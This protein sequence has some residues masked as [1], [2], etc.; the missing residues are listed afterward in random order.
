MMLAATQE[1]I[2]YQ[3]QY[4]EMLKV[5]REVAIRMNQILDRIKTFEENINNL[6]RDLTNRDILAGT[7]GMLLNRSFPSPQQ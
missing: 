3:E 2:N 1:V 7:Q 4:N 5:P 6:G